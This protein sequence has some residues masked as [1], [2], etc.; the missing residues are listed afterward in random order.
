MVIYQPL[1]LVHDLWLAVG[2]VKPST[3]IESDESL[4]VVHPSSYVRV[5][6]LKLG[7][8]SS[9]FAP[10]IIRDQI[11]IQVIVDVGMYQ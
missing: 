1:S 7:Q 10:G 6:L 4:M 9:P 3:S 11:L 5:L 2:K 8:F